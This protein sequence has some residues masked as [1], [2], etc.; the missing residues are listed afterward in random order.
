[1]GYDAEV[2]ISTKVDTSQMQRLRLQI[3][4]AVNKVDVLTQKLDGLKNQ[5]AP[6]QAYADLEDKLSKARATLES[7]IAEEERM[8]N[9]GVAIGAPWDNVIQ[10]E[11]DAQLKIEAI[12]A[13]MQKLVDTGKAF[14]IGAD[15][16]EI[17]NAANELARAKAEL[18]MLVTKQN[19]LGAKSNKVSEGLKKIGTA[20][21][22]AFGEMN[23]HAKK[24]SGL[25]STFSSRLKGLALSLFVF[26]W[27]SKG[28][29][30]M[31]SGI[32]DGFKNL[33]QY[34]DEYNRSISSLQSA[35]AQ[36]KNSFAAAFAP[37]I[38]MI[39]PYLVQLIGYVTSAI[40][41]VAQFI[42]ILSG[43]TTWTRATAVQKNYAA[44]LN[45][46]GKAA[47]KAAGALAA[48]DDLDVLSKKDTEDASGAGGGGGIGPSSMFEEVPIDSK[49][50]DWFDKIREKL[51]PLLDY[52]KKL[53]RIAIKGFFD[54][55]GDYGYRL[56]IIKKGLEKIKKALI[57]IFSDPAVISAAQG[58]VDSFVYMLFTLIGAITSI[59]LTIAAAFIGGL[60]DY[61]EKNVDRIRKHL[62]SMFDI[63][64][65]IHYL[66]ADLFQ[67]VAY[68]FE[69]F[70]SDDGIRFVSALIGSIADAFMGVTEILMKIGRDVL[71]III[72]PITEN[73]DKFKTALEG[74]LAAGANILEGFKEMVDSVFDNLN[75]VYDAHFKPFLDSMA[76]GVAHLWGVILDIWNG[77]VSP[78]LQ[79]IGSRI[80]ELLSDYIA[81]FINTVVELLGNLE[82]IL[83]YLIETILLPLAEL[84]ITYIVPVMAASFENFVTS[85]IEKV[86]FIISIF[87]MLY[88][89]LSTLVEQWGVAWDSARDKFSAFWSA[90]TQ[91]IASLKEKIREFVQNALS[92][93]R[94][95]WTE[96]WGTAVKIFE[97]FKGKALGVVDGLKQALE[98]FF[99]WISDMVASCIA[100]IQSIGSAIAGL[101]SGI[102]GGISKALSGAGLSI[103]VP[104][105]ANGSVIRGGNPFLAVLGDQR[106]GQTNVETPLSTIEDAVR[107]VVGESAGTGGSVTVNLNYDGETFARLFIPNLMSE[108]DRQGYDVDMLGGLT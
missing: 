59:A 107:N 65:E 102:G 93:V 53:G 50:K 27:I 67:S 99:S 10:K 68:I 7:L 108:L 36:L 25:L 45:K 49:F 41:A 73:K 4:K 58:Y 79:D 51:K 43:K 6:T 24:S 30:A 78:M 19:E 83:Q 81:P 71:E 42:A 89:Y 69:A 87:T 66:L 63:G 90:V 47:K 12:Q 88:E 62:L 77:Q 104:H 26:N 76:Q 94:G 39:I 86:E 92:H 38:Q 13:E 52:L 18:R 105:L 85:V 74:L 46:T 32:K 44:S 101:G 80:G 98:Q 34:S 61:F 96:A 95:S 64:Q 23:V 60:G 72:T 57:D 48:F 56:D 29:N 5:K 1:M 100:K 20:G 70:A 14:T 55:L 84:V 11:A 106:A 35:N 103:S 54:G 21:K 2:R 17:N 8:T 31:V 97:T 28:F 3:D 91:W 15:P 82:T 37:I 40:N 33:V 16:E 22:K 9:A 75:E